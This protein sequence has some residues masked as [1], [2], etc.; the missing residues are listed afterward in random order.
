[1]DEL[2]PQAAHD[3]SERKKLILKA[4]VDA[5]IADGEPV[6]SKYLMES[7]R[8]PCSS[9][10]IR[11]EM[12]ELEALGYLEQPHTSAGRVP[13]ERGYRFYVDTMRFSNHLVRR[14]RNCSYVVK[15]A[16]SSVIRQ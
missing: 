1:M 10:T 3:L 9:A 11:N 16:A 7:K 5:H 13:S 2:I 14:P 12:A 6:G 4:I 8:I 15:A